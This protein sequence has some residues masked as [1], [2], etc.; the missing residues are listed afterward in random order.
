MLNSKE[1]IRTDQR[2]IMDFELK[3]ELNIEKQNKVVHSLEEE[4]PRKQRDSKI[5]EKK[6]PGRS[7]FLK[8]DLIEIRSFIKVVYV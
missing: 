7:K 2:K 3:E 6:E 8:L 1:P 5:I 4:F